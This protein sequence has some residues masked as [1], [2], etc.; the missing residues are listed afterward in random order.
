MVEVR[1][2]IASFAA[3]ALFIVA[4]AA[5]SWK[6]R[7]EGYWSFENRVSKVS[8]RDETLIRKYCSVGADV[9]SLRSTDDYGHLAKYTQSDVDS[10]CSDAQ[11]ALS[12]DSK[13]AQARGDAG[14]KCKRACT[15]RALLR[16]GKPCLNKKRTKCCDVNYKNC[17]KMSMV[18]P[19]SGWLALKDWAKQKGLF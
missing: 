2:A 12:D 5:L 15:D 14:T 19:A 17:V 13:E 4:V 10:I 8:S 3:V 1:R 9:N 7:R 11:R 6:R 16:A 18:R